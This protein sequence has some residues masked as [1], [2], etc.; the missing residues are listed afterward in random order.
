VKTWGILGDSLGTLVSGL[1]LESLGLHWGLLAGPRFSQLQGQAQANYN[2]PQ[3]PY[4]WRLRPDLHP[5]GN[6][7]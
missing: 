1:Q 7:C 5:A 2:I 6:A 3:A 4:A